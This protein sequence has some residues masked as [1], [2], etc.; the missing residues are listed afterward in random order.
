ME[1]P[2]SHPD[3][4]APSPAE[5]EAVLRENERPVRAM[6]GTGQEAHPSLALP[7]ELFAR[8]LVEIV[9]RRPMGD[10]ADTAP[11]QFLRRLSRVEPR[12]I[13]LAIACE[14]R[15]PGAWEAFTASHAESLKREA[16]LHCAPGT[17]PEVIAVGLVE[18]LFRPPPAG[19]A[20]T[21]FGTWHGEGPL[22]EW[23]LEFL[24]SRVRDLER[25]DPEHGDED[26]YAVEG[27]LREAWGAL[28]PEEMLALTLQ[29][30]DGRP[31]G[32]I[33]GLLGVDEA[34]VSRIVASAARKLRERIGAPEPAPKR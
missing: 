26:R 7:Y 6:Y 28:T 17:D 3:R 31:T 34:R 9:H 14:E 25:G 8:R 4:Q 21:R 32:E 10:L 16:A 2:R 33:A 20:R 29:V 22:G 23:L 13:F 5:V 18:E 15:I 12:E 24:R 19:R 1:S 11:G 27:Q 30:R